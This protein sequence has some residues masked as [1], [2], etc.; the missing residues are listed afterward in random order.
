MGKKFTKG[1]RNFSDDHPPSNR[2]QELV[3]MVWPFFSSN[4]TEQEEAKNKN[5]DDAAKAAAKKEI[6]NHNK[7]IRRRKLVDAINE[8]CALDSAALL[9]CQ[10]S[11]SLW[12]RMTLCQGFQSKYMDCLNSQRVDLPPIV[13]DGVDVVN[14]IGVWKGREFS[15]G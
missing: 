11:W 14:T 2:D 15:C 7:E 3:V 6:S 8:N 12:N 10:D 13:V 5:R 9:E 4:A 1:R